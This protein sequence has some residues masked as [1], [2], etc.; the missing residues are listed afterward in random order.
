[1]NNLFRKTIFLVLLLVGVVLVLFFLIRPFSQERP[2]NSFLKKIVDD[3]V[4]P[5][6][7]PVGELIAPISSPATRVTKKPFGLYVSPKNYPVSPE[8][9]EGFHSGVD[10]EIFAD[11]SDQKIPVVAACSGKIL[12][13]Q[14][15]S[16]YG[17]VLAQSCQLGDEP[18][19]LVYG[20]L[21]LASID[22]DVG[23]VFEKGETIGVLGNG[24]TPET[25]GE[26]K[27]LHLGIHKGVDLNIRGY[28]SVKD[29]LTGWLDPC[30]YLCRN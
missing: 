19:T 2:N 27:H 1:M 4:T 13:K 28:V 17:G 15:A 11:E 26:R 14:W 18:V 20:H 22:K 30:Q 10:F 5:S 23:D 29:D 3:N 7:A 21:N 12:L 25:D 16:G 6:E 24:Y 9:F 8:K